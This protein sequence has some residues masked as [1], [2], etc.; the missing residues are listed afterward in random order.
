MVELTLGLTGAGGAYL[1]RS[2]CDIDLLEDMLVTMIKANIAV[3]EAGYP[4]WRN[5]EKA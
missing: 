3:V 5:I 4:N 1:D 2:G